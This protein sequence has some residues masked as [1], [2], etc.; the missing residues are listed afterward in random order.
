[1]HQLLTSS[2]PEASI[3]E[4]KAFL[5]EVGSDQN[6]VLY[7]CQVLWL[8]KA[9]TL[10]RFWS[11]C[12]E[13]KTFMTTKEK[14][15]RFLDSI[16]LN[17]LACLVDMT[18]YMAELNVRL[19]GKGQ[20]VHKLYEHAITFV[21]KLELIQTHLVEKKVVHFTAHSI[22]PVDTVQ[23][24]KYSEI[25]AK[26]AADFRHRSEDFKKHSDM[27][28]LLSNPFEVDPT[29]DDDE[30][31]M[32]L[33]D[34]QTDWDLKIAFTEHDLLRFYSSDVSSHS[35][36]NLSQDAMKFF[37]LCGST[38]CCEQLFSRMK[39]MKIKSRSLLSNEHFT[40]VGGDIDYLCKQK[41]CQISY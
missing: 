16:W 3:T 31:Q 7:F 12:N 13:I 6:D 1:M 39:N 10:S 36:P 8:S 14:D 28:K 23:H 11:L 4:F 26:L 35:Y 19:Q 2:I 33:I 30:Y 15:A 32:E 27:M 37:A 40:S 38:Y 34:I 25:V 22:R 5:E 24:E 21:Q 20:L 17:D 41:Q 29:H 18:K 9:A